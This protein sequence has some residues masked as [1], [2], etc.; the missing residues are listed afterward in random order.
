MSSNSLRASN[1]NLNNFSNIPNNRFRNN[2][3]NGNVTSPRRPRSNGNRLRNNRNSS[4]SNRRSNS[5]VRRNNQS[6]RR[7]SNTTSNASVRNNN[8][9]NRQNARSSNSGS[10]VSNGF[11]NAVL[12]LMTTP[13][14]TLN[15]RRAL[16]AMVRRTIRVRQL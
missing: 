4:N 10:N 8:N 1:E 14:T 13:Q 15:Q 5:T 11:V 16:A 12:N 3:P 7:N 9:R 2:G 6:R